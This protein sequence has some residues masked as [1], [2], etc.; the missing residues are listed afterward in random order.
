MLQLELLAKLPDQDNPIAEAPQI[1]ID[2]SF[3]ATYP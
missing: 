1:Y 3:L 2:P